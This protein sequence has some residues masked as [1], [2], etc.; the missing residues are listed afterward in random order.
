[1]G[2]GDRTPVD[3]DKEFPLLEKAE[4]FADSHLRNAEQLA[5][6]GYVNGGILLK[7]LQDGRPAALG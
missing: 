4:V 2:Y 1:M 5:E 7:T 6:L 3:A